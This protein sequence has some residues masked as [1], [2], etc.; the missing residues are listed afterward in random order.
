[1]QI[2]KKKHPPLFLANGKTDLCH[3]QFAEMRSDDDKYEIFHSKGGY[4]DDNAMIHYLELLV[5]GRSAKFCKK[6]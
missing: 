3:R 2:K 5:G 4:T 6:G 1:M